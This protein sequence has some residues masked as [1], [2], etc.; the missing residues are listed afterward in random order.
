MQRPA[1]WTNGVQ[2]LKVCSVPFYYSSLFSNPVVFSNFFRFHLLPACLSSYSR[3]HFLLPYCLISYFF[4]IFCIFT[5]SL[6]FS[7]NSTLLLI[8]IPPS[9]FLVFSSFSFIVFCSR[10]CFLSS[11]LFTLIQKRFFSFFSL[12]C[13]YLVFFFQSWFVYFCFSFIFS[14]P[15]YLSVILFFSPPFLVYFF[16]SSFILSI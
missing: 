10:S 15:S 11:F 12:L 14:I 5:L 13:H 4:F 3:S 7:F 9:I 2:D 8:Y 16:V 1:D 6:S